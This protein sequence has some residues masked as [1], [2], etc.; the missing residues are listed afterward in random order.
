MPGS[1]MQQASHVNDACRANNTC[2]Q[3]II[4]TLNAK[5]FQLCLRKHYRKRLAALGAKAIV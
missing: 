3:K 5:H 1:V 2:K 4:H